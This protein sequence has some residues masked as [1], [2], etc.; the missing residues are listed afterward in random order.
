VVAPVAAAGGIMGPSVLADGADTLL[1]S[2][3]SIVLAFHLVP[4][5]RLE[6]MDIFA[7]FGNARNLIPV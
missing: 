5:I 4:V 7:V 3:V 2:S 6:V 1:S